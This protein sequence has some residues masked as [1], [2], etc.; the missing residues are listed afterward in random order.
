MSGLVLSITEPLNTLV[1]AVP[2]QSVRAEDASGSFG[3]LLGRSDFL[4]V[5]PPSVVRWRAK[6][7]RQGFCALRSGLLRITGGT[8]VD[9]ACRQGVLG[10]DLPTLLA[11]VQ[12]MRLQEADAARRA[13]TEEMRLHTQTLRRLMQVFH[14]N[15]GSGLDHPPALHPTGGANG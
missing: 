1:D 5:L 13:R 7:G 12:E 11:H 9:V 6:D 3:I 8:R 14:P 2:V 10:D 15:A 4:T